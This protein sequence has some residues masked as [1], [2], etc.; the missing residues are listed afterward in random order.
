MKLYRLVLLLLLPVASLFTSCSDNKKDTPTP[1]PEPE[2]VPASSPVPVNAPPSPFYIEVSGINK[3]SAMI[4]WTRATDP[5]NDKVTYS[6]VFGGREVASGLDS[7]SATLK[8]LTPETN[9]EGYV[10]AKDAYENSTR[11]DFSFTTQ[12]RYVKFSKVYSNH[13]GMVFSVVETADGGY[14]FSISAADFLKV[15]KVD[16]LGTEEWSRS[17]VLSVL[18]DFG[19]LHNGRAQM[20]AARDGGFVLAVNNT[21][22]RL[23]PNGNLLWEWKVRMDGD[24]EAVKETADGGFVAIGAVG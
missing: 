3:N 20:S 10:L 11:R 22:L 2:P 5:E 14:A 1:K 12:D 21:V 6:V 18:N 23:D 13:G 15:R 19:A 4:R 16:S 9:Y 7:T 17:F 8:G 24:F